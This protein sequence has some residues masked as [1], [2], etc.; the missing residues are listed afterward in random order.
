[1]QCSALYMFVYTYI[2]MAIL[3]HVCNII[4]CVCLQGWGHS[5]SCG[6]RRLASGLLHQGAGLDIESLL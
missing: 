3:I 5:A 2:P 1:M 4:I 6:G